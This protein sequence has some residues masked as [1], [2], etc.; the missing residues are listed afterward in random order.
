[1]RYP[2]AFV[3]EGHAH[4]WSQLL[5]ASSGV[6]H[7][8]T[9]AG[10]WVVP[11]HRALFLPASAEHRVVM[12]G[13]VAMRTVYFTP[14][15][16]LGPLAH[17]G[18]IAVV[19]VRPLLRELLAHVATLG[20]LDVGVP[21]EERLAALLVD[22]VHEVR[23]LPVSLPMPNDARALRVATMVRR[24][25]AS[26]AALA[27]LTKKAGASVRTIERLFV[28]ETGM[29]F[30]RWRQQARLLAALSLLAE[31]T[32]VTRVALEVGYASPSA[33]IATFKSVFGTTPSRFF[34]AD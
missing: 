15:L 26:E 24:D 11:P 32:P 1:M 4:P 22:L 23:T 19:Q 21:K 25:P 28:D 7:V 34:E 2:D 12:R 13:E 3:L 8:E 10:A 18:R 20:K 17:H 30:G 16:D 14:A 5:Y 6:M 29:T 33:F 27:S 31:R 9:S